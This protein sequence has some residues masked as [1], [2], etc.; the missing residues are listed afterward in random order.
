MSA[1]RAAADRRGRPNP[2][3]S[4]CRVGRGT[5]KQPQ[6]DPPS[7]KRVAGLVCA[8]LIHGGRS[9]QPPERAQSGQGARGAHKAEAKK[10][11]RAE[12]W[13][14]PRLRQRMALKVVAGGTRQAPLARRGRVWTTEGGRHVADRSAALADR[15]L[16]FKPKP[17]GANCAGLGALQSTTNRKPLPLSGHNSVHA[18]R[19]CAA[20]PC[21]LACPSESC[22][23]AGQASSAVP[24]ACGLCLLPTRNARATRTDSVRD[25]GKAQRERNGNGGSAE[26]Q[27]SGAHTASQGRALPARTNRARRPA[28]TAPKE[29]RSALRQ[30]GQFPASTGIAA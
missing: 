21:A 2:Y 22:H 27:P 11:S 24:S 10:S 23:R 26:R 28:P 15:K 18:V 9:E 29:R 14:L 6:A 5:P 3:V 1:P 16:A 8:Q 4:R 30:H 7:P 13:D 12:R 25:D 20:G 19:G 17:R